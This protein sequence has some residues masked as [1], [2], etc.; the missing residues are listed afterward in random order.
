MAEP[1]SPNVVVN[2]CCNCIPAAGH[3]PRQFKQNGVH[4]LV[5]EVPCSGKIDG[6]YL[7][8][9]IEGVT[10]GLCVMACPSGRCRL[11]QGNYR[12]GIRVRTIQ[13][14]LEE[15]GL[16]PERAELVHCGE[17]ESIE[18]LERRA[19]DAVRRLGNLE[20][21]PLHTERTGLSPLSPA[22]PRE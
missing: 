13:R 12:A 6:Q 7:L 4:V 18:S 15:I 11:G 20:A 22:T 10:H 1:L 17:N 14:L 21:S 5:R 9:T 3:L 19:R 16:E 8:H 2:V